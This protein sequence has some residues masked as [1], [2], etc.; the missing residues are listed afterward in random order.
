VLGKACHLRHINRI[1][2]KIE[3]FF[4][5]LDTNLIEPNPNIYSL[6]GCGQGLSS[7]KDNNDFF[8]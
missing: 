7:K 6:L 5:I 1:F 4:E 8:G 2:K 3:I